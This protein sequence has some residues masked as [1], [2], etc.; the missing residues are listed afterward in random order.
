MAHHPTSVGSPWLER[1]DPSRAHA[2]RRDPVRGRGPW[3]R[4][5]RAAL[6][7]CGHRSFSAKAEGAAMAVYKREGSPFYHFEFEHRGSRFRGSTGCTSKREAQEFER[8][9]RQEAAKEAERREALGR[10]PLTW[11]VAA[12]RYWEELGQH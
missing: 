3:S 5:Q 2:I 6:H 1:A 8:Q 7:T 12:A 11:G 4:A 10:S 9:K